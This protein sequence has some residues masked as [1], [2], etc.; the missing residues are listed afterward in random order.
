MSNMCECELPP[1]PSLVLP[2]CLWRPAQAL[3]SLLMA[4]VRE[5]LPALLCCSGLL[6]PW[7]YFMVSQEEFG[8]KQYKRRQAEKYKVGLGCAL[9]CQADVSCALGISVPVIYGTAA[10]ALSLSRFAHPV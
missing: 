8:F 9:P 5:I 7:L 4:S 2:P 6:L 1:D 3:H 10:A